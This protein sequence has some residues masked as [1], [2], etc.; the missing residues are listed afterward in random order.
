[1][2]DSTLEQER[3]GKAAAAGEFR[4]MSGEERIAAFVDGG[5]S[6]Y[7]SAIGE[8]AEEDFEQEFVRKVGK[9]IPIF[10]VPPFC[11]RFRHDDPTRG[12]EP[13]VTRG[14]REREAPERH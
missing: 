3:V 5:A 9:K 2:S 4:V 1:M 12:R 11:L 10:C 7:G 6:E 13:L 8:V 14:R